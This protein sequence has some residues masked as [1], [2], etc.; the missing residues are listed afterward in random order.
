MSELQFGHLIPGQP[1][2]RPRASRRGEP[3]SWRRFLVAAP[4]FV[5]VVAVNTVLAVPPIVVFPQAVQQAVELFF[6]DEAVLPWQ[7]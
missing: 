3:V 1:I 6:G 4:L 5:A 2:E 7:G